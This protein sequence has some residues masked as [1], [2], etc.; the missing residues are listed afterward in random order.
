MQVLERRMRRTQ[1]PWLAAL[2]F[3][4]VAAAAPLG[5]AAAADAQLEAVQGRLVELGYDPSTPDGIMGPR[6]RE[7]IR[8][9]Q[10]DHGLIPSG[11][12]DAA[13]LAA[14]GLAADAAPVGVAPAAPV[15][16]PAE[17]SLISYERIGWQ[18]P[19]SAKAVRERFRASRDAPLLARLDDLLIVPNPERIYI[20]ARG[21]R[22]EELP[23]DPVAS[24]VHAEFL[25]YPGGPVLFTPLDDGALCQLG[26][27]IVLSA[28]GTLALEKVTLEGLSLPAGRVRFGKTGLE[29]R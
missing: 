20:L 14:L 22:L 8:A 21:A 7:A 3:L 16:P 19:A 5:S 10:R 4:A 23:C 12:I 24:V 29:F 26:L 9:L 11:R 25:L 27:G 15:T 17:T 6:T 1:R 28:E 13:T 2:L 18:G